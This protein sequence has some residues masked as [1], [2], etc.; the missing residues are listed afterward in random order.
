MKDNI[1]FL[2]S[3]FNQLS[4]LIYLEKDTIHFYG[5][6]DCQL[7]HKEKETII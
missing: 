3:T 6:T 5:I 2:K 1:Q 7:F 4:R